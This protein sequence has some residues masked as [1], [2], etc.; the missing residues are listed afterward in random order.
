VRANQYSRIKQE[1]PEATE[2]DLWVE[3]PRLLTTIPYTELSSVAAIEAADRRF[4]AEHL[5][6]FLPLSAASYAFRYTAIPQPLRCVLTHAGALIGIAD[7]ECFFPKSRK[8]VTFCSGQHP[9]FDT[10]FELDSLTTLY[11]CFGQLV[12]PGEELE[13]RLLNF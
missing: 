3:I 9:H 4:V 6:E 12:E 2:A 11:R 5:S 8:R 13:V 10:A 7:V 1:A